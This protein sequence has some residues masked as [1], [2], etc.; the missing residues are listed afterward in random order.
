MAS[1]D[2]RRLPGQT[3][4]V[5][6]AAPRLSHRGVMPEPP[7]KCGGVRL[8]TSRTLRNH[9]LLV[10]SAVACVCGLVRSA[11]ADTAQGPPFAR[12]LTLDVFWQGAWNDIQ[13]PYTFFVRDPAVGREATGRFWLHRSGFSQGGLLDTSVRLRPRIALGLEAWY[14][15]VFETP[16]NPMPYA[17]DVQFGHREHLGLSVLFEYAAQCA[18]YSPRHGLF[19][20]GSA[21]MYWIRDHVRT[22]P[23]VVEFRGDR[24]GLVSTATLGYRLPL[25]GPFSAS[26]GLSVGL[27][28]FI[29]P[30]AGLR[31]GG[32]FQ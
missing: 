17:V 21:G 15:R 16:A 12:R 5:R 2:S 11:S 10:G 24:R 4:R 29:G 31:V 27:D 18:D 13:D 8:T 6:P 3:K 22:G 9:A 7:P 32:G 23:T 25:T 26:A 19:V 20:Q 28:P 30:T 1:H 14:Q